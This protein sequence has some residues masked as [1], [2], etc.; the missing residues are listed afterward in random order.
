M[1]ALGV[2]KIQKVAS[3]QV[4]ECR[5][6]ELDATRV[7]DENVG[8][9]SDERTCRVMEERKSRLAILLDLFD[10]VLHLIHDKAPFHAVVVRAA[11]DDIVL[12]GR[13]RYE[14]DV[15][16]LPSG[17]NSAWNRP[18]VVIP[19]F[20]FAGDRRCSTDEAADDRL[21]ID[22]LQIKFVLAFHR[23]IGM[24]QHVSLGIEDKNVRLFLPPAA[25]GETEVGKGRFPFCADK[26]C[27]VI[28]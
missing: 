8:V 28:Y 4:R 16:A 10:G 20:R 25:A 15:A 24:D 11:T 1:L 7:D 6:D 26:L 27:R 9:L 19:A 23:G 12:A 2:F 18:L 5:V 3:L 21:S 22:V 14:P 17:K 13:G